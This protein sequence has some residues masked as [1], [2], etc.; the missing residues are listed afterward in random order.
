MGAGPGLW[1]R[2]LA[3]SRNSPVT[4]QSVLIVIRLLGFCKHQETFKIQ[5]N[6]S[7]SYLHFD[8]HIEVRAKRLRVLT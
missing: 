3:G 6:V 1:L 8:P 2:T 4:L 5:V 7:N